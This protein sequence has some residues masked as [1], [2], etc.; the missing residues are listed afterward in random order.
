MKYRTSNG[1]QVTSTASITRGYKAGWNIMQTAGAGDKNLAT[2]RGNYY[3]GDGGNGAFGGQGGTNNRGGGG[4]TGYIS[5]SA[6]SVSQSA[7]SNDD[8][9]QV[10]IRLKT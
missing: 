9:A 7:G 10:I 3:G 1:S 5:N 4:G 8:Q 6:T 2:S